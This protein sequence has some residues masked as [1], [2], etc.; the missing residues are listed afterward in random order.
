MTGQRH[1]GQET[2]DRRAFAPPVPLADLTATARRLDLPPPLLWTGYAALA[3]ERAW[4][5]LWP[6]ASLILAFLALAWSGALPLLPGWLHGGILVLTA[7]TAVALLLRAARA[8]LSPSIPDILRRLE[9]ANGLR[10][11]PL[12]LLLD[13]PVADPASP[14]VINPLWRLAR[15]RALGS[16]RH[17]RPPVP[18]PAV[19]PRDPWALRH[20]ALLLALVAGVTAQGDAGGRLNDALHPHW[21]GRGGPVAAPVL[22]VWVNPPAYTGL[23][24]LFLTRHGA[25]SPAPSPAAPSP[26]DGTVPTIPAGAVVTARLAGDGGGSPPELTVNGETRRLDRTPGGWQADV[27]II[28]GDRLAVSRGGWKLGDWPIRVVADQPPAITFRTPPGATERHTLRLDYTAA[29]DYGLTAVRAT[30]HPPAAS[31]AAATAGRLRVEEALELDLPLERPAPRV[32][33]GTGYFD[34]TASPWAGQTVTVELHATDGAGQTTDSDTVS[35]VLPERTFRNPVAQ[36]VIAQRKALI[37]AG[38]AARDTVS[39]AILDIA[40]V[41]GGY[42]GDPTLFMGLYAAARRLILDRTADAVD[43]VVD[44]LWQAALRIEDGHVATAEADL[45]TAQNRL[46]DALN[47]KAGSA[48]VAQAVADL[49]QAMARFIGAMAGNDGRTPPAAP[50]RLENAPGQ[51]VDLDQMLTQLQQAAEAGDRDA[52]RQMLSQLQSMMEDVQNED[53]APSPGQEEQERQARQTLEG[54]TQLATR[55]RALMDETFRQ[56]RRDAAPGD[57][58]SGDNGSG[59]NGTGDDGAPPPAAAEPRKPS[60]PLAALAKRQDALRQDLDALLDKAAGQ[61]GKDE[62]GA[63]AAPAPAGKSAGKTEGPP[64]PLAPARQAMGA[65]AA[66]LAVP[67]AARAVAAQGQA[68]A[69]LEQGMRDLARQMAQ[70]RQGRSGTRLVPRQ[71]GGGAP[72]GGG[73]PLGR[74]LPGQ[75]GGAADEVRLPTRPDSKRVRE[76]LDELRRRANDGARPQ[77][78]RDYIERLLDKL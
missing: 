40:A 12:T 31:P 51:S 69:A 47:R 16:L 54:L 49:K 44:L 78:E 74:A 71:A 2:G 65:A 1:G 27:K 33:N 26:A 24:P 7:A 35:V 41:P 22:D 67:D 18:A 11:Q 77:E 3:W 72:P 64:Q 4:R 59:D 15:Q 61:G 37:L 38:D 43:E 25:S 63:P 56:T 29:D 76:I 17:L 10:H 42:G 23:S 28:S 66:A 36:A 60:P 50:S 70:Q 48:E 75:G 13:Q 46:M 34:L 5:G 55:Q 6:L 8:W 21:S 39:A 19:A 58:G 62:D 9:Q 14:D 68:L 57:N 32:A 52:A 20:L 53:G 73:D 30:I 45:R